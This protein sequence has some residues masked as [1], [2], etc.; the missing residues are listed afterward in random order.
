MKLLSILI[1]FIV[2]VFRFHK[3]KIFTFF[4]SALIFFFVL[5]PFADLSDLTAST[6]SQASGG[7]VYIQFENMSVGMVPRPSLDL[8][9]A[10][11]M[12]RRPSINDLRIGYLSFSPSFFEILSFIPGLSFFRS[13]SYSVEI[14]NMFKGNLSASTKT[15]GRSEQGHPLLNV[16]L[17]AQNLALDEAKKAFDIPIGIGGSLELTSNLSVD[18]TMNDGPTGSTQMTIK[19]FQ[20]SNV[21]FGFPDIKLSS[22]NL[23]IRAENGRLFIEDSLIGQNQDEIKGKL[24]G[25]L[26]LDMFSLKRGALDLRN[27]QLQ[28]NIKVRKN[29]AESLGFLELYNNFR[30]QAQGEPQFYQYLFALNFSSLSDA[31]GMLQ[32][33]STQAF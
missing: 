23:K 25:S 6:V 2:N 14:E 24:R 3:L 4:A 18:T 13:F 19:Q 9:D 8:H 12:V 22:L 31:Q 33:R 29:L 26:A 10:L 20:L 7:S 28:F 5:F 11:I 15:Q 17:N 21:G 27:I 16:L 1:Q 32:P 30:T